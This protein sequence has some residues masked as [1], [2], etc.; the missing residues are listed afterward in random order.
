MGG[1]SELAKIIICCGL[2][3]N[4]FS[5]I[6]IVEDLESILAIFLNL[7]TTN[8]QQ[9]AFSGWGH[10]RKSNRGWWGLSPTSEEGEQ[11]S[12][13]TLT[14]RITICWIKQSSLQLT[15]FHLQ[16]QWAWFHLIYRFHKLTLI[17][18]H[19]TGLWHCHCVFVPIHDFLWSARGLCD[20]G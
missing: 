6:N 1:A 5:I 19:F 13:K 16:W 7:K 4:D 20:K 8:F 2:K 10:W 14:I 3:V 17:L 12:R 9:E 15:S 18:I 11:F